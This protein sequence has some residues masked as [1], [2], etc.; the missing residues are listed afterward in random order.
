MVD[1]LIKIGEDTF[2]VK[3]SKA[4]KYRNK[5]KMK[6]EEYICTMLVEGMKDV[7]VHIGNDDYGQC[8]FVEFEDEGEV[9]AIGCGTYNFD[10]EDAAIFFLKRMIENKL[11]K[12][13][14]VIESKRRK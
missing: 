14:G 1:L 13:G 11:E 7:M 2:V 5:T 10:Y 4:K 9:E 3:K 8:Y 12:V 6:D